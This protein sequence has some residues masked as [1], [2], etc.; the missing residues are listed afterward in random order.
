MR[1]SPIRAII[2]TNLRISFLVGRKSSSTVRSTLTNDAV[3]I[4]MTCTFATLT[5]K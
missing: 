5:H 2:D 3:S 4:V 1:N